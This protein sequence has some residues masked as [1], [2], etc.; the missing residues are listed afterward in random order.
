MINLQIA[1]FGISMLIVVI[2]FMAIEVWRAHQ[3]VKELNLQLDALEYEAAQLSGELI[4]IQ[5]EVNHGRAI[6]RAWRVYA[7]NEHA[8]RIRFSDTDTPF[9]QFSI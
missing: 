5:E 7:N 8:K 6:A 1:L 3:E 9:D 2:I 4:T